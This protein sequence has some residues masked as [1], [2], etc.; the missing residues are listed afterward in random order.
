MFIEMATVA[1]ITASSQ[2]GKACLKKILEDSSSNVSVV[3]AVF[4]TH[5]RAE[6][7]FES[8]RTEM[9]QSPI[10]VQSVVGI[11]AEEPS[12]LLK[13]VEGATFALVVTP[14]DHS[15]GF[16]RDSQLSMNMIRACVQADVKHLVYVGSWTVKASEEVKGLA[17]RFIGSE[18]LLQTDEEIK[19]KGIGWTCLRSGY[20]NTN[21]LQSMAPSVKEQSHFILPE[22]FAVASCDVEDIGRV[23]ACVFASDAISEHNGKFYDLSGPAVLTVD[24]FSRILSKKLGRPVSGI[25]KP[26]EY[27]KDIPPPLYEL[28]Q[29]LSK[30]RIEVSPDVENIVGHCT[31]FEEWLDKHI[32]R[33][34]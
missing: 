13:A 17:H 10:K 4:R 9:D 5:R 3:R 21:F 30:K 29:Y 12:S 24:D 25:S 6:E 15:R 33:F 26:C 23:A 28:I 22:G 20:F 2:S 14:L 16:S 27:F 8:L 31:S 32:N 11:D 18:K 1:I 34:Q 7:T 19:T